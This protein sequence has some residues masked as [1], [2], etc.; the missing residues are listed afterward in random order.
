MWA[1]RWAAEGLKVRVGEI[2]ALSSE[3]RSRKRNGEY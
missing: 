1:F 3:L 2:S